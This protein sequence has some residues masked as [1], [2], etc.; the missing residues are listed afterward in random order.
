MTKEGSRQPEKKKLTKEEKKEEKRRKKELKKS[1]ESLDHLGD[2]SV[3]PKIKKKDR[4]SKN[5]P[6]RESQV[7]SVVFLH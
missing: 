7:G 2:G 5:S 3:T 4:S 6:G 1:R